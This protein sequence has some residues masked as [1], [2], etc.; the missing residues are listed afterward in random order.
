MYPIETVIKTIE[1]YRNSKIINNSELARKV[2]IARTTVSTWIN[3]YNNNLHSQ[4]LY[5]TSGSAW[6]VYEAWLI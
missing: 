6:L 4:I 1:I 2:K 5:L 3:K